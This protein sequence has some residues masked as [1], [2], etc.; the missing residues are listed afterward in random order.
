[1]NYF[2]IER[3]EIYRDHIVI[4]DNEKN[5][6]VFEN[7]LD[8]TYKEMQSQKDLDDFVVAIMDATN[9]I[10]PDVNDQTI[11][12]LIGEDDLFIWSIIMGTIDGEIRYNLI[13]WKADG[14]KYRYQPLD[15]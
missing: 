2:V 8:M 9:V 14:K 15:K 10:A 12:T 6:V 5:D 7:Y 1:M 4:R 13:N 3:G 11:I